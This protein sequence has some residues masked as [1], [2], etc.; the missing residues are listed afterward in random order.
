MATKKSA[1]VATANDETITVPR[2]RLH[3]LTVKNFR[4]IG[5]EPVTLELDDIVV[6]VG[7]NNSGKSSILRAYEVVMLHGSKDGKLTQEDFPNAVISAESPI[8]IELETVVYDAKAPG[9]KWIRRDEATGDMFV[10]EKWT[11]VTHGDPKK[12]GWDVA[13]GGWH[14]KEGPWGAAGVAQPARPE[15]HRIQAFD[16]PEKQADEVVKLLKNVLNER[17]KGLQSAEQI[18]GEEK[19]DYQKLITS[20]QDFQKRAVADANEEIKKVETELNSLVGKVFPGQEIRFDARPDGDVESA[21]NFFKEAPQLLMGPKGGY[22]P[23]ID[24]QGSGARRTL[25]WA[26]LRL[27]AEQSR[28][29]KDSNSTRPHVLLMDEP[30][31]CLHPNAVREACRVL[32]D[33]PK[34]GKWQVIVT[35]H[36]PVFIDFSRDNTSIVRVE[37]NNDGKSF[38]TTIYR[39]TKAH[40]SEDEREHL[41]LLNLCDPYVAEFF[42][43]GRTII[44]EGDT[45]YAAFQYVIQM[46]PEKFKDLHVVRARGKATIRSLCKVLNQFEKPYAVLHDSDRPE[47]IKKGKPSVNP[48]WTTNQNIRE[49]IAAE[50][51]AGKVTL[52]ASVPNFEEAYFGEEVKSDKPFSAWQKV[53]ADKTAY[54]K[55]MQL[56]LALSGQSTELPAGALAWNTLDDLKNAVIGNDVDG[57]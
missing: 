31:L 5:S 2:P 54:D 4:A 22:Q 42:F 23:S 49:V 17:I 24:R 15:P 46:E 40:L 16:S 27:L 57:N 51:Q 48:A 34:S 8:E 35:T 6:L 9:E 45:E 30:E 32:Y 19:N 28:V 52:I 53:K 33:L 12:V 20:I 14:E 55:V 25:L 39:P 10:R 7:P 50:I 11:W 1:A 21:L 43:G 37:R 18:E 41:K 29:K 44:V 26:A 36:S 38:G 47:V 3:R 13:A 56:L